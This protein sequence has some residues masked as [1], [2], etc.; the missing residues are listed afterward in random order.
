MPGQ[1]FHQS[2]QQTNNATANVGLWLGEII[3]VD[4]DIDDQLGADSA[5][6]LVFSTLGATPLIRVGRDPRRMC[7]YLLNT[8]DAHRVRS[9]KAGKVELLD[10]G[11]LICTES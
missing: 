5:K 6:T 11:M 8:E 3:A 10:A 9:W 4:I 2:H 7:F 1:F